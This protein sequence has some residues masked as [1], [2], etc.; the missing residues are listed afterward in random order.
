MPGLTTRPTQLRPRLKLNVL[1]LATLL[2]SVV[3]LFVEQGRWQNRFT[4]VFTNI[5]DFT[6]LGLFLA[7]IALDA[8]RSADRREF[9]RQRLFDLLFLVVFAG[10]FAYSKYLFFTRDSYL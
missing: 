8:A 1:V 4:L 9:L 5:L 2:L 3:S 10:L 7:E 6:V